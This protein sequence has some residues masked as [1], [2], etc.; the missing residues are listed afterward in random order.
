MSIQSLRER[1]NSVVSQAKH[2]LAEKG[3]AVWTAEEKAKYDQLI[4]EADRIADQI[5]AEQKIL[6]LEAEN[7]F[8]DVKIQD[9]SDFKKTQARKAV[10][11][12]LRKSVRQYTAEDM[13]N[14]RATMSTTTDN[15]GGYTVPKFIADKV[16]ESV[17]AY[18]AMRH[19][20]DYIKTDGGNQMNW[21]TSDP[22]EEGEI[23]AENTQAGSAD[24]TFG[25]RAVN[26][27]KF[28]SKVV[29]VPI[30][31]VQDSAID[32]IDL[33][34]RRCGIRIG[35]SQDHYFT[36]GTG[37]AQ[38]MG[39]VS[40]VETG[41]TTAAGQA[42]NFTY[43]DI[44]SLIE[45]LDESYLV[46][47]NRP[48]FM[49]NQASRLLLRKLKDTAGRPIWTPSF[50]AGITAGITGNLC[51]YGVKI[52]N[53]M[54]APAAGKK[55]IVFGAFNPGYLVRDAM[56][57]QLFRFDDSA[58]VSKGQIGFLAWARAGGN[59]VDLNAL[60]CLTMGADSAG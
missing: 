57:V 6:D 1:L 54:D 30:E 43:D 11:A 53:F 55:P 36:T 13:E 9:P 60:K 37:T 42:T 59:V 12:F 17:K 23:V 15:Q 16:I 19:V 46:G 41:Y 14:I 24:V 51:G 35:R 2:I 10:E 3:D 47:V 58:Y 4:E 49:M 44:V 45:S 21:P 40:A 27:F 52:N 48:I 28:S 8:K 38:P 18:G 31:L 5:K 26:V 25:T 32:I 34:T 20:S 50:D 56:E 22:N 39:V 7:T 29:A 33:V